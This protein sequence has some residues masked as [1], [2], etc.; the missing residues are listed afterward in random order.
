LNRIAFGGK[1]YPSKPEELFKT[2]GK[3]E[4]MTGKQMFAYVAGLLGMP[5]EKEG[6]G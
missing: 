4:A 3:R 6:K 5:D 2:T 1:K